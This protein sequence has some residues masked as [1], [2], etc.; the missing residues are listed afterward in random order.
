MGTGNQTIRPGRV[1]TRLVVFSDDFGRHPSSSQHLVRELLM[2]NRVCCGAGCRGCETY[3]VTWVNTVGTRT[4]EL[5][6][7][8]I[9]RAVGKVKDWVGGK[10]PAKAAAAMTGL[11][12]TDLE[13]VNPKMWPGF[14]KRWQR[15]VNAGA[16][17]GAVQKA[18]GE[19]VTDE[20]RIVLTTLPIT[21]DLVGRLDVDR[22]VYYC[23]DD[24]S[25]WPGLDSEV[26]QAMEQELVGKVDDVVVVSETLRDRIAE[27]GRDSGLL[28]HGIDRGHWS[29]ALSRERL[30]KHSRVPQW[31]PK[32]DGPV[33]LFWGL[34]D[35]RLD[36]QW[37]KALAGALGER[38]GS[39][40]LAGPEQNADASVRGLDNTVFP[41]AIGYDDLPELASL[42]DVLVMPYADAAVTRA[43]QPLKLKEY[44]ATDRPVVVRDLPATAGW[45]DCCD[46][47]GDEG[48]FVQRCLERAGSGL[49]DGQRMARNWRLADESWS[50]K[51]KTFACVWSGVESKPMR[52]AA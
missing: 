24:F 31:W 41:G 17:A 35:P 9:G 48:A 12:D 15:K 37:C 7:E 44:L 4:P 6:R 49:L 33:A 43:M 50:Q 30:L 51:A 47:V 5:C 27:M 52:S 18:L 28:T 11:G 3:R 25:V 20:R 32:A 13:V 21:A 2:M 42:A 40:V 10:T 29:G 39:L 36:A 45:S 1:K 34:I 26:M 23:V 46:V 8:D 38:G 16:M 14:R 22:W 19:R